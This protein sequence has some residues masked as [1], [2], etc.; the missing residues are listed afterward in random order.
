MIPPVQGELIGP[1]PVDFAEQVMTTAAA[2]VFLAIALLS[3][4]RRARSPLV[5]Q[6]GLMSVAVTAYSLLEVTYS[7]TLQLELAWIEYAVASLLGIPSLR[8]F[9]GF[10]GME[11]RLRWPIRA[12]T[13]GYV[14]ITLV[15]LA[16]FVVPSLAGFPGNDTWAMAMLLVTLPAFTWAGILLGRHI[17]RSAA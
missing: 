16:A 7:T 9:I 10:V 8:L 3:A 6:L 15:C 12:C 11:R 1:P 2:V 5:S 13:L 14:A 4:A 17:R